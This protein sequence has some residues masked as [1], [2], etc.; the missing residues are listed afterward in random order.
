MP[1]SPKLLEILK[2][3]S[4]ISGFR[5]CV[6]NTKWEELCAWPEE[7]TPFCSLI[8]E[9][10]EG[11]KYCNRCDRTAFKKVEE[12]G[13]VYLY[14][15][16]FG[17]YEAVAPLYHL[18]MLSGYLMMGQTLDTSK[19][20]RRFVQSQASPYAPDTAALKKAVETIPIRSKEQILSCIS[21]MDICAAYITL[22]DHLKSPYTNLPQRVMEYLHQNYASDLSIDGLCEIFYCS[23]ATLTRSFKQ[24]FGSSVHEALT[25][26]RLDNSLE[27]LKRPELSIESIAVSCGFYD[28]NYYTK[29]FKKYYQT[30]P[31]RWRAKLLIRPEV[32]KPKLG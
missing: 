30:T 32:K 8:Q 15:C 20:S 13:E 31:G 27:L 25:A 1:P 9:H 21:I 29:V 18:G 26:I 14:R 28:Q 2:N 6:Y 12:T 10:P 16:H 23:R 11:L 5:I 24:A 7:K 17:L 22:K 3:L 4:V 19:I